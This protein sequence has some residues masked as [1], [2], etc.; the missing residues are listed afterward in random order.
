LGGYGRQT[1]REVKN[2]AHLGGVIPLLGGLAQFF[3]KDH[4][5]LRVLL[6]RRRTFNSPLGGEYVRKDG[7]EV[8]NTAHPGGVLFPK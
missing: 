7:K 5:P 4:L 1:G 6:H 8:K 3:I 2:T